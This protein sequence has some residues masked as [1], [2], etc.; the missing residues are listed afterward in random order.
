MNAPVPSIAAAAHVGD[1]PWPG[2]GALPHADGAAFRVWAPHATAVWVTGSFDGWSEDAHPMAPD[3]GGRWYADIAGVAEGDEYRFRIEGPGGIVSRID[4][5]AR[6]VTNS[7]GNGIVTA[8]PFDW[9]DDAYRMP[10][11]NELVIY[12]MHLGTFNRPEGAEV[13][14]FAD[15]VARFDH[16][17]RVGV[18]AIQIMPAAEF[19]GDL[20][21]GYNPAHL[22][23]VESAYGGPAAFKAFVRE[24]HAHGFAV[25][26]DVVY[27]HFGPSDLDLW[28]F[29]GWGEGEG[30]G[31]YFYQDHRAATPWG[32]TRPDY[33]RPE[34][35]QFI[36]DNALHWLEEFRVD[37]LRFDMTL[38]IRQIE[39]NEGDPEDA[40]P[41]GWSL[42]QW[43]ND[44]VAERFPGRIT[45]AEDL[46]DLAAMTAQTSDGG[47]GF[48]AQWDARF[49]HPVREALIAPDDDDRS[50]EAIAAALTAEDG[51]DPFRR[52]VYT[53]SHDEVANGKARVPSEIGGEDAQ[54]HWAAQKRSTL[55]AALVFTAA[56]IPMIFQGQEFLEGG[57]FDDAVPLDWDRAE[58]FRGIARLYRDLIGLRREAR[59]LRARETEVIHLDEVG[60]TL[61]YLRGR[62]DDAVLVILNFR[63][64][65][66]EALRIGLPDGGGWRLVVNTDW[67]GYSRDFGGEGARDLV[68]EEGEHDGR[69]FHA[70]TSIG[71]FTALVFVRQ[72]G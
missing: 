21:W 5:Y 68:P 59:G 72:G 40:L 51:G 57:W 7:V 38:Y 28:R 49:V 69:P 1:A 45:I 53:E 46:R 12:E 60:K 13:G 71:G 70:E 41:D 62:G 48:G 22:F 6:A 50:M 14:G 32:A 54:T 18:N 61:A 25:I 37:G 10:A 47:A 20:S 15:A 55:G 63:G 23:A 31:V 33:G 56:G 58:G 2:M 9:G 44:E 66:A 11:W 3:E 8:A 30:G 39:G 42:M 26:L 24:A 29:D 34:V 64:A 65:P 16:L 27:N 52:V 19:A 43:V 36:R 17:R 35:R 67:E 4:P